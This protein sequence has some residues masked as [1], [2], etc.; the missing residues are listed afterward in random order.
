MIN[1]L[2]IV[3]VGVEHEGGVVAGVVGPRARRAVVAAAMGKRCGFP[4]DRRARDQRAFDGRAR[5]A[6]VALRN[7]GRYRSVSAF[8]PIVAPSQVPWGQK[9]FAAYV[10]DDRAAWQAY[11][12]TALVASASE[13]LPLLIDQGDGPTR[14]P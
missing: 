2:D 5:R 11:D 8:S 12:A 9:A 1:R 10:G 13:R 14:V 3:A 4:G 6:G 7:P